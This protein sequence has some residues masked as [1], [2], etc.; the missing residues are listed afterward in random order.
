[1]HPG[2]GPSDLGASCGNRGA[3][4]CSLGAVLRHIRVSHS[5]FACKT[6]PLCMAVH[7]RLM[8]TDMC[9]M[10]TDMCL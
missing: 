8:C 1:M 10:C 5:P 9:L 4:A 3:T 7:M 6:R 2:Q